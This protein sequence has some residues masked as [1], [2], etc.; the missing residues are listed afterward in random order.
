MSASLTAPR[1]PR[2]RRIKKISTPAALTRIIVI[3]GATV[4]SLVLA[5]R[6]SSS[7]ACAE[8]VCRLDTS[9]ASTGLAVVGAAVPTKA[10]AV[11]VKR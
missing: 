3:V 11:V 1:A 9:H 8:V 2:P 10:K 6:L 5:I 4:V 7:N